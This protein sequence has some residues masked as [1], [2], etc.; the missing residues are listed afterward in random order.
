MSKIPDNENEKSSG[1]EGEEFL[2][3]RTARDSAIRAAR[4]AV[5][6]TTRLT[7]LLTVL[8]ERGSLEHLLER[9]LSTLSELFLADIVVLLDP[10]GTGSFSPLAAIG[11]PEDSLHLPFSDEEGGFVHTLLK[12]GSPVLLDTTVNN[13]AIDIQLTDMGI[14]TVVG[15]PVKESNET[16]GVLILARCRPAPFSDE[17][18]SLLLTMAYRIG[19]TI[20]ESQQSSQFEKIIQSGREI[21]RHLDLTTVISEVVRTF[22][23]IVSADAS[24]MLLLDQNGKFYCASQTGLN[25]SCITAFTEFAEHLA[26][27]SLFQEAEHFSVPDMGATPERFSPGALNFSPVRAVLAIPIHRKNVINGIV[28]GFRFSAI[29]FTTSTLQVATIFAEQIS[30]AIENSRLYQA[31]HNELTE[32]KKLEEERKKWQWQQQQLQKAESLNRMA[33]A[34]AH[35]FNNM[36][37]AVIGNIQLALLDLQPGATVDFLDQAL[38]AS[39]RAAEVSSL[40]LTYLGQSVATQEALRLSDICRNCLLDL[41]GEVSENIT[42]KVDLSS[43][44]P[45]IKANANQIQQALRNLIL[46]AC[47]SL[48]EPEGILQMRI[49]TVSHQEIPVSHRFPVDWTPD[50]DRFACVEIQDSGSGISEQEMDKIFDPFFSTK[51][52]GRG[53]GLPVTLGIVRAHQGLMTVESQK[54][55]GSVFK[56]FL[57]LLSDYDQQPFLKVSKHAEIKPRAAVLIVD[58]ESMVRRTTDNMLKRMGYNVIEAKDGAEAVEKFRQYQNSICVVLCDLTLPDMNGWKTLEALNK[59]EPKIPLILASG[60]SESHVMQGEH[61][62]LPHAFLHKPY[63]LSDLKKTLALVLS[64]ST[65]ENAR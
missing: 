58:D 35:H 40:M 64:S 19:Q 51:F 50:G 5:R 29:G 27:S 52:T 32:R 31:V 63:R 59:I 30:S 65:E 11:I 33:G 23:E 60:Y 41:E 56:V 28:F 12:S 54:E 1:P 36:L 14:E 4:V 53:L 42:F 25:S 39:N 21:N 43:P 37:F 3:L 9:V 13:P 38:K 55:Q 62:L 57:P 46:N 49:S 34:I 44:G 8:N 10:N 7:R 17:D 22:P 48:T 47:E 18:V 61:S 16:R 2:R 15:L 20:L 24:A 26:V 6:D 45:T